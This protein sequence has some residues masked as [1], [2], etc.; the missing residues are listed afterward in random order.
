MFIMIPRASLLPSAENLMGGAPPFFRL[1]FEGERKPPNEHKHPDA[2][3]LSETFDAVY[4]HANPPGNVHSTRRSRCSKNAKALVTTRKNSVRTRMHYGGDE[5]EEGEVYDGS[6]QEEA[7]SDQNATSDAS[8]R[9]PKFTSQGQRLPMRPGV[10]SGYLKSDP[11]YRRYP[12]PHGPVTRTFP[13]S[14]STDHLPPIRPV[15]H[16]TG[17]RVY[18]APENNSYDGRSQTNQNDRSHPAEPNVPYSH[19]RLGPPPHYPPRPELPN[20]PPP[21]PFPK[22][23]LPGLPAPPLTAVGSQEE[24]ERF[25][26]ISVKV[27]EMAQ[28][29]R[30][31]IY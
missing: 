29:V 7:D 9:H 5:A 10:A 20:G 15:H 1:C 18:E 13:L 27:S 2:G 8:P 25:S 16:D 26:R 6:D 17:T 21:L 4:Q 11:H 12:I 22:P 19:E 3:R 23:Q 28:L 30:A 14:R 31:Q 24:I